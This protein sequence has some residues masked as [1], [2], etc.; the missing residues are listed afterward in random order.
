[1]AELQV[2]QAQPADLLLGGLQYLSGLPYAS[3]T[4]HSARLWREGR[5]ILVAP[6]A[7]RK[8]GR[9]VLL[10]LRR[11]TAKDNGVPEG[12]QLP[13]RGH[14][15]SEESRRRQHNRAARLRTLRACA[16]QHGG[17]LRRDSEQEHRAFTDSRSP[18]SV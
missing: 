18:R 13:Q 1:M 7:G 6:L 11:A 5:N 17:S 4:D 10:W 2:F 3:C 8:H 9:S 14:L 15:R 16:E 12:G